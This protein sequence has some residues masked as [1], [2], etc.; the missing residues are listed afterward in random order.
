MKTSLLQVTVPEDLLFDLRNYCVD[1]GLKY[2][3]VVRSLIRIE[4]YNEQAF[5]KKAPTSPYNARRTA[6]KTK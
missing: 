1:N 6:R 4:I 2:T 3:D 5:A